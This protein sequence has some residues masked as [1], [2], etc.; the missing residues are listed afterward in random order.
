MI[1]IKHN[2]LEN[3][4]HQEFGRKIKARLHGIPRYEQKEGFLRFLE[5]LKKRD[6]GIHFLRQWILEEKS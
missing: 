2:S 1:I 5:E 3:T 4:N 6:S